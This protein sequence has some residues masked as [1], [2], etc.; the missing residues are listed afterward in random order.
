MTVLNKYLPFTYFETTLWKRSLS[1]QAGV[2][3][4]VHAC[5]C[6]CRH[7]CVSPAGTREEHVSEL[8]M[9][10]GYVIW[11]SWTFGSSETSRNPESWRLECGAPVQCLGVRCVRRVTSTLLKQ[12]HWIFKH[13]CSW[14]ETYFPKSMELYFC[15]CSRFGF[16][17]PLFSKLHQWII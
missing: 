5:V 11:G 14:T 13:K 16:I 7:A 15:L 3:V 1:V 2:C 4:Q 6:V 9:S 8:L 10:G 17:E 12:F